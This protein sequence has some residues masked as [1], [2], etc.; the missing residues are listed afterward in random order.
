M[1][2]DKVRFRVK[3]SQFAEGRHLSPV[4]GK[5]GLKP[6]MC[7]LP[8]RS[9]GESFAYGNVTKW[10]VFWLSLGFGLSVSSGVVLVVA[11]GSSYSGCVMKE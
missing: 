10:S 9:V 1:S 4:A 3:G 6:I 5:G 7:F 2:G 8:A 11:S